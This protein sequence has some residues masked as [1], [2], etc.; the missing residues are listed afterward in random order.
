MRECGLEP[1]RM[2][3]ALDEHELI[4]K[5][6]GLMRELGKFPT[7]NEIKL[8]TRRTPGFPWNT[9]FA[10]LGSKQ[11]LVMRIR[12]YCGDRAGYEDIVALCDSVVEPQTPASD[13]IEPEDNYGFVYLM[14]S[15]R[16]YKSG[17]NRSRWRS[18]TR[19]RDTAAR[20]GRHCA[21]N[22]YR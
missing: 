3:G 13:D 15:G 6:I 5:L 11:Q 19:P 22:S 21:F 12:E 10:R 14:K 16:Y 8:K 17:P 18:R 2:Q 7:S 4:E 20:Q 1:N 9:T